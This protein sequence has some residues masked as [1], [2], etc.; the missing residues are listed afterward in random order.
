MLNGEKLYKCFVQDCCPKAL[1]RPVNKLYP[2]DYIQDMSDCGLTNVKRPR[3][4]AFFF[5]KFLR[6]SE[7]N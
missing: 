1:K 2:V 4:A 7:N 3:L 5:S 6:N